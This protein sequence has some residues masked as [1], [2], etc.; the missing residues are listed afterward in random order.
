MAAILII[1]D[2]RIFCDVLSRAI[3]RLGH[4]V[5]FS[6]TLKEGLE[7]VSS[8]EFDV[9]MLD[10]QLPDGNGLTAISKIRVKPSPPEVIIITGTGDPDGAELAIKWGA[11][12]YVEKPA[13]IEAMTLPLIRALEYRREKQG[14]KPLL[15]LDRK[16]VIG[17]SDQMRTCLDLLAQAADSAVNIL[18]TGET[19]TGKELLARCTHKN[20]PR[21]N[22]PFVV[23]DCS[24]LPAP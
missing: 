6:L 17:E 15:T 2:D 19:G 3:G 18:I 24:A 23:V 14:R 21:A 16:G 7:M 5:T 12:D 10:V 22:G 4:T 1:D 20:S 8:Q 11:W 9:V 13:S